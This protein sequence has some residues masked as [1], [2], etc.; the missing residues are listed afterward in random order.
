[1]KDGLTALA[2]VDELVTVMQTSDG[3]MKDTGDIARQWST[4]AT[5]LAATGNNDCLNHFIQ[6]DGLQFLNQWLQVAQKCKVNTSDSSVEES[7]SGLLGAL[8]KLPIDE[9]RLNTCG[10]R[11]T[12]KPLLTHKSLNVQEIARRL[13][14]SWHQI[15]DTNSFSQ[16]V[17]KGGTCCD[18][19]EDEAKLSDDMKVI[20][21]DRCAKSPMHDAF[22]IKEAVEGSL[23]E[24]SEAT[25]KDD[26]SQSEIFKDVKIT[27]SNQDAS[28]TS[29]KQEDVNGHQGGVNSSSCS[30]I[31][32]TR[33]ESSGITE[34]SSLC[35]VEVTTSVG[36]CSSLVPGDQNLGDKT[37]SSLCLVEVTTS[38]GTCSSLVPG[39]QNLGDKSS[40]VSLLKDGNV[41]DRSSD[42][43][44]GMVIEMAMKESS[45]HSKKEMCSTHS[46]FDQLDDLS[47]C[48]ANAQSSMIE[49]DES[50][51]M[52]VESLSCERKTASAGLVDDHGVTEAQI[53]SGTVDCAMPKYSRSTAEAISDVQE[54]KCHANYLQ[55]LA[56]SGCISRQPEG[57]KASCHRKEAFRAVGNIIERVSKPDLFARKGH[58]SLIAF[59]KPAMDTK[60]LGEVDGTGSNVELDYGLDDALEVAR[61]VAKEVERE[62]VDYRGPFCSSSSGGK[63]SKGEIMQPNSPD[64]VGCKHDESMIEKVNEDG[65]SV[66][67]DHSDGGS[68]PKRKRLRTSNESDSEPDCQ[69]SE[70][71]LPK[72]A[73]VTQETNDN[74]HKNMCDFDLN[75]DVNT[76]EIECSVI[77]NQP[78]FVTVPIP[79]VAALKGAPVSRTTP[80]HFEGELGW[81]G[82]ATTSA[83]RR[84]SPR[85]T[86]DREKTSLIEESSNSS[87]QRQNL[88]EI[89]L[90]VAL[91]DGDALNLPSSPKHVPESSGLH[92][93][94]SSVEV[95]STKAERLKLD[96]N[97]VGD[98]EDACILYSSDWKVRGQL[99]NHQNGKRVQSPASSSSSRRTPMRDFDLNDNPAFFDACVSHDHRVNND[100]AQYQNTKAYGRFK[101]DDPVVSIMG[102]KIDV[103]RKEFVNRDPSFLMNGLHVESSA[104][105]SLVRAGATSQPPLMF[106][107][108]QH[109]TYGYNGLMMRPPM[110]L[111]PQFYGAP[112]NIPYMVD[113]RGYAVTPHMMG[114]SSAAASSFAR[115]FLMSA[116]DAPLGSHGAGF[117]PSGLDLNSGATSVAAEG[118][119]M[120]TFRQ[121]FVQGP[122]SLMEEQMKSAGAGTAV[123]RKEPEY[124]WEMNPFGYK[125]EPLLR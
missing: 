125:H 102:S 20:A 90:N 17:I 71:E 84:A 1:M 72:T 50:C 69:T 76:Q 28:P 100:K 39:D 119:E 120:G 86:P 2:R 44:N 10:I 25:R 114:S 73:A 83:F 15:E 67:Q 85:G 87:K 108:M 12:I 105:A 122:G 123:K 89:D 7:I 59:L 16:D 75:E 88:L 18:G 57:P 35:H 52:D 62:V 98:S 118:N 26:N 14:D 4:V 55:D 63:V 109:P 104:T 78:N 116:T 29:S 33:R 106:P 47:A 93:A 41:D 81:R 66:E 58:A 79:V 82:S 77:V 32:N 70:L 68:S 103:N 19:N 80:L 13:F 56:D 21:E 54:G 74:N 27:T 51:D 97:R 101:P 92:S 99:Y 3:I 117:L 40:D 111:H 36:T 46:K 113:S 5:I 124:A 91:G 64:S 38:V 6:S 42:D 11:E 110:S 65:I 31:S 115:P 61:R 8:E 45:K 22:P 121:L 60:E 53:E 34:H 94:D 48:P 96:L 37:H 95:S 30:P 49:P 24:H 107:P 9:E 43:N 23:S 112:G